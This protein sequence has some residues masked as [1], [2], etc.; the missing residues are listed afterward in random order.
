MQTKIATVA[1]TTQQVPKPAGSDPAG[2]MA[3]LTQ[4]N[5]TVGMLNLSA[6]ATHCT[7]VVEEPGVYVARVVRMDAN[8]TSIG[9]SAESEPVVVTEDMMDVPLA[10][11]L[12]VQ[13]AVATPKSIVLGV[14]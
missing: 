13:D 11:T 7:F 6:N 5:I 2:Y 3:W 12:V 10:V 14:R 9:N 1:F 8:G 4:N